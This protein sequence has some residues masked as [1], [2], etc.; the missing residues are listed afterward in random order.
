[1]ERQLPTDISFNGDSY[2]FLLRATLTS[3]SRVDRRI[4][5]NSIGFY[6]YWPGPGKQ[7]LSLINSLGIF[8]IQ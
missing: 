6:W 3:S 5:E 7:F 2:P 1:M 8:L 4:C